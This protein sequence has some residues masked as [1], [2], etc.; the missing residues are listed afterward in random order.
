M[1]ASSTL[2]HLSS[3]PLSNFLAFRISP[4]VPLVDQ[5]TPDA[6]SISPSVAHERILGISFFNGTARSAVEHFRQIGGYMV[7]PASPALVKLNYDE[8][9]RRALQQADLA[10]ADSE[11]LALVWKA[12]TGRKTK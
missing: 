8:E 10:I 1:R 9:Y 7:A 6:P 4:T 11:L 5:I 12:A 2:S 3:F